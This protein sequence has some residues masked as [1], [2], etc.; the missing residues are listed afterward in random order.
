MNSPFRTP[1]LHQTTQAAEGLMRRRWSVA[2]I[3]AMVEAG[4]LLEDERFELIGGEVVPMSPKGNRH[5]LLKSALNRLWGKQAPEGIYFTQETTFY[6]NED[7]FLEPDFVFYRKSDGLVNLKPATALLAVEVSDSSLG[8]DL[9][10]K[11]HLYAVHG[12]RQVWIID[13]VK[14]ETHI[15]RRPG[16]DG[17]VEKLLVPPD[18]ELVPDFAPE[19]AVK[20]GD[21]ELV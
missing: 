6:I 2:E 3:V 10:R 11:S 1:V 9:G 14:L 7:T 8:Y 13:A 19:L 18:A 17:Y 4:I 15:R 21:L 12:I 5:E 20:L 16:L